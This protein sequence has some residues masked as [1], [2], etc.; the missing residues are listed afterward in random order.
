MKYRKDSDFPYG[1]PV[2]VRWIDSMGTPGWGA[3]PSAKMECTSVGFLLERTKDRVAIAQNKSHY[4]NGD[5]LEIPTAA[6]KSVK[7]LK[8]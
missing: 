2:I 8:E 1:Q 6:I 5:L 3:E 4:S 7:K